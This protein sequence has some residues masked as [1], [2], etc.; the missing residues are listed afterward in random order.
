MKRQEA[1]GKI[2]NIMRYLSDRGM[3]GVVLELEES[4]AAIGG[5][6]V[7]D[8][9]TGLFSCG[10]GGKAMLCLSFGSHDDTTGSQSFELNAE[11]HECHISTSVYQGVIE[12]GESIKAYES[13]VVSDWNK[14][15][16]YKEETK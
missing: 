11:C 8:P 10:C 14:A 3:L 13:M 2:R 15:R 16:G 6:E 1:V 9:E 7:P 4:L 5:F 12:D